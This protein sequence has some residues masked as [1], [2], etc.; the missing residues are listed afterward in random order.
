MNTI[1]LV[2]DDAS[3][4]Q[5]VRAIVDGL[6]GEVLEAGTFA[7]AVE[8]LNHHVVDVVIWDLGLPDRPDRLEALKYA[9]ELAPESSFVVLTGLDPDRRGELREKCIRMGADLYVDK[10]ATRD[11]IRAAVLSAL[12]CAAARRHAATAD[13]R[14]TGFLVRALD[15]A[16][17]GLLRGVQ[18]AAAG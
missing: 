10:G 12:R 5:S 8:V 2:D 18:L 16:T 17:E 14:A 15:E 13:V 1:L 4:R 6:V 9:V 11:Q 7:E 3:L